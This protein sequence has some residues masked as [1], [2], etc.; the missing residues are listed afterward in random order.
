[1]ITHTNTQSTHENNNYLHY[2]GVIV[3]MTVRLQTP[4]EGIISGEDL[5]V[6]QLI[7]YQLDY[8]IVL[9][10]YYLR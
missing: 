8:E 2:K 7:V 4:T 1:V 3:G 6:Y 10:Y 5:I 9:K